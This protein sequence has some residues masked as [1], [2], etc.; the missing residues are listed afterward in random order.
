[1][2]EVYVVTSALITIG[3]DLRKE[4]E[5]VAQGLG[6]KPAA[7]LEMEARLNDYDVSFDGFD[8]EDR[9]M[10]SRVCGLSGGSVTR[11]VRR[12]GKAGHRDHRT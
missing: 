2:T 4:V 6:V 7:V 8:P 3:L 10:H 1:M 12:T 9:G 5:G 11:A